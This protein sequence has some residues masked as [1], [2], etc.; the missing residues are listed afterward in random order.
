MLVSKRCGS[1]AHKFAK[2][3]NAFCGTNYAMTG[4]PHAAF[5]AGVISIASAGISRG[6]GASYGGPDGNLYK[7]YFMHGMTQG[8]VS[9][10]SGGNFG[11]VL[12]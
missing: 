10:F 6:I 9:A 12:L 11:S 5:K 3:Q 1:K 8:A 7:L 2:N 4:D